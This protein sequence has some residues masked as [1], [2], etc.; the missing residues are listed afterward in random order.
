M[1]C[2]FEGIDG[3]GKTTVMNAVADRLRQAGRSLW[4]TREPG[5]S[6]LGQRLR[7]MLLDKEMP[8][9]QRAELML[10]LADRA[11][12][13]EMI[14]HA[15]AEQKMVLCDRYTDST[16]AYQGYGR[17]QDCANLVQLNR[18]VTEGL[19]ADCTFLLDVSVEEAVRRML[20]RNDT[21]RFDA[22]TKLF[23]ERVRAG[24]LNL[25]KQSN[26]FVVLDA[27]EPV[28]R[29]VDAAYAHILFL[30]RSCLCKNQQ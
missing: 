26:R 11:E 23:H 3:S 10:F 24:Y 27:N 1:F 13:V 5:G 28:N 17:G 29:V 18:I 14:R 12:H 16:L 30:E 21:S 2:T 7:S 15:L 25:A 8:L 6:P 22:E 20:L 19:E 4:V 9:S